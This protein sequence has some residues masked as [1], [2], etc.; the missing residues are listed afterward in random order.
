MACLTNGF[1]KWNANRPDEP[2]NS[3][4]T[5]EEMSEYEEKEAM[6]FKEV[7]SRKCFLRLF[8]GFL[9]H[10]SLCFSL[11]TSSTRLRGFRHRLVLGN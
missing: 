11:R 9:S 5:E 3:Q 4:P 7:R 1:N 8:P 6:H 10:L 2:E